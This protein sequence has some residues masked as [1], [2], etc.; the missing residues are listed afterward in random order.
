MTAS[1]ISDLNPIWLA[2]ECSIRVLDCLSDQISKV[3]IGSD[4]FT[5]YR[6]TKLMGSQLVLNIDLN[7]TKDVSKKKTR[8]FKI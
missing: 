7:F 2:C 3:V 6:K 8:C 4:F 1:P 5:G